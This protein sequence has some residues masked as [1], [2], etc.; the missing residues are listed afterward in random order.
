MAVKYETKQRYLLMAFFA[1]HPDEAVPV[2]TIA[3][4]L[5]DAGVSKASIYRNLS[6][7]EK[8]G[9]IRKEAK[10]G[11]RGASYRYLKAARCREH[12]HLACIKCGKTFHLDP[13]AT[14][15]L[16]NSVKNVAQFDIDS[17]STVLYGICSSCKGASL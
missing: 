8:E 9:V 1:S 13:P 5:A 14:E 11:F 4:T 3:S 6:F 10:E 7:L 16:I 15:E 17:T 2:S 12:M